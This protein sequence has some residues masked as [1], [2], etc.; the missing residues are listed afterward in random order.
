M[1]NIAEY[2][3]NVN[4]GTNVN[5][6]NGWG[7]FQWPLGVPSNL[8]G[9]A[10]YKDISVTVRRELVPLFE[11][12][13]AIADALDYKIWTRDP[14]GS[15]ES[16]GPWSYENRAISGTNTPSNHSRGRAIDVNAPM[17]PYVAGL[18]T[19][20]PPRFVNAWERIGLSWG[21]RYTG[22]QDTMHW[23]YA[24]TPN[25]VP[26]HI[27]K[28]HQILNDILDGHDLQPDTQP[29]PVPAPEAPALWKKDDDVPIFMQSTPAEGGRLYLL[30]PGKQKRWINGQE[31]ALFQRLYPE[32]RDPD[33]GAPVGSPFYEMEIDMVDTLLQPVAPGSTPPPPP[34]PPPVKKTYTVKAGDTLGAIGLAQGVT[35]ANLEAWVAQV[36][37]LNK[38]ASANSIDPGQ[39]LTL[40]N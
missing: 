24:W 9:Q 25:D 8:L 12:A 6:T 40:P 13:F 1:A 36:V 11:L 38:L 21:G 26:R 10:R 20:M 33:T 15:G 19:N 16:W 27:A 4:A 29:D 17:N 31:W 14:D 2:G 18:V 22:R 5:G 39:V 35:R 23:E 3:P 28:A 30:T 7:G 37:S 32:W 34:P